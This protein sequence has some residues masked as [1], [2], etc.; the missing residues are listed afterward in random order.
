MNT[1]YFKRDLDR[2]SAARFQIINL[3]KDHSDLNNKIEEEQLRGEDLLAKN[4]DIEGKDSLLLK[5]QDLI[6][7]HLPKL[8]LVIDYVLAYNLLKKYSGA[9]LEW[10]PVSIKSLILIICLVLVETGLGYLKRKKKAKKDFEAYEDVSEVL[11]QYDFDE[12]EE[13][14]NA[15]NEK[16][17]RWAVFASYLFVSILPIVSLS[18]IFFEFHNIE[19]IASLTEGEG[20]FVGQNAKWATILKVGGVAFSSLVLHFLVLLYGR[21]ILEAKSRARLRREFEKVQSV[22]EQLKLKLKALEKAI[23]KALND[24]YNYRST[25]ILKY[26]EHPA[27]V[28]DKFSPHLVELYRYVNGI[29]V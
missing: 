4:P 29:A 1:K 26:G 2:L 12:E 7:G 28:S 18:E 25:H 9:F 3:E 19:L 8:I 11:R 27:V 6:I 22:I 15:S 13:V 20:M 23:M 24:F 10:I 21:D 5:S 16:Q 14:V 17:R